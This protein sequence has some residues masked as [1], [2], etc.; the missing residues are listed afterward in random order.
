MTKYKTTALNEKCR[1]YEL[2]AFADARKRYKAET[3]RFEEKKRHYTNVVHNLC[4]RNWTY[5]NYTEYIDELLSENNIRDFDII[6]YNDPKVYKSMMNLDDECYRLFSISKEVAEYVKPKNLDD[7]AVIFTTGDINTSGKYLYKTIKQKN[8]VTKPF[9]MIT[10]STYNQFLFS[11]QI[12]DFIYTVYGNERDFSLI[13]ILINE[14]KYTADRH[15]IMREYANSPD[16]FSIIKYIKKEYPQ[17]YSTLKLAYV[18]LLSK[19]GT[20]ENDNPYGMEKLFNMLLYGAVVACD[21]ISAII[22]AK[23]FYKVAKIMSGI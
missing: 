14:I 5:T 2:N 17:Y 9:D 7:L 19:L 23:Q 1:I 11:E 6:N 20:Y 3:E 4:W 16:E 22:C 8:T 12:E 13:Y 18:S 21:K 15:Y 10:K